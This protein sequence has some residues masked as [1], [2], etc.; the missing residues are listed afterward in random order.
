M[1]IQ[2]SFDL[3][4]ASFDDMAGTEI[5]SILGSLQQ[6]VQY[7]H[8]D[9]LAKMGNRVL[10]DSNGNKIGTFVVGEFLPD[11]E[12]IQALNSLVNNLFDIEHPDGYITLCNDLCSIR[13][14]TGC[15][16]LGMI[17][18]EAKQRA[19]D[20]LQITLAE[21]YAEDSFEV[22]ETVSFDEFRRRLNEIEV[23]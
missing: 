10:L 15:E 19:K 3:D 13:V 2:I 21:D 6:K 16:T 18:V 4:N 23:C 11:F 12:S 7:L 22:G 1:K 9:E 17:V 8:R 5:S 20:K 14:D